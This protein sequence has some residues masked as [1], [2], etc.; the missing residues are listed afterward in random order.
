MNNSRVPAA[1]VEFRHRTAIQMRFGDIDMFGHVNNGAYLQYADT[2]K[3]AFFTELMDEPFNPAAVGLVI[4]SIK[5]D[6]YAQTFMSDEIEVLTAV[7]HVGHTSLTVEQRIVAANEDDDVH[8]IVSTV[9]V[10]FDP[11]TGQPMPITDKWR[12]RLGAK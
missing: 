6:Y 11:A 9:M 7:T 10:Q 12:A 3:F 1:T 2:A 4:A 8:A 5:C